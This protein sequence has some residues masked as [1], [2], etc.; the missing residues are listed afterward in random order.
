MLLTSKNRLI[1]RKN[2]VQEEVRRTRNTNVEHVLLLN[3]TYYTLWSCARAVRFSE[4]IHKIYG[5]PTVVL[6]E[7]AP[8]VD[9]GIGSRNGASRVRSREFMATGLRDRRR[10]VGCRL[11][12]STR[13]RERDASSSSLRSPSRLPDNPRHFSKRPERKR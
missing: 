4:Y 13:A 11:R 7:K 2:G 12:L 8:C 9:T 3:E 5:A 1:D 10:N 6:W